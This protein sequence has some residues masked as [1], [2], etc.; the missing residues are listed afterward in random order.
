[1]IEKLIFIFVTLLP[2]VRQVW[3]QSD[4]GKFRE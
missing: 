4:E 2:F 1:M 3:T